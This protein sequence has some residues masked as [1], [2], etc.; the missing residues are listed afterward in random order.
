MGDLLKLLFGAIGVTLLYGS[1]RE[2]LDASREFTELTID[3]VFFGADVP[4]GDGHPVMVLPGLLAS[5]SY[6]IPLRGWLGRMGYAALASGIRRNT[7]RLAVLA[8]AVGTRL[9]TAV[10]E[11]RSPDARATLIGHSFGGV[12]ARAVARQHPE[13]VR[14]LI[15]LGSPL[16]FDA[17][18][19][20]PSIPLT[21]IYT[22]SDR[23][24]RY[25]RALAPEGARSL[26]VSG[27]HCGMAFN[28]QVYR[29]LGVLLQPTAP[30]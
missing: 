7:G 4:R 3:P 28:A 24:V 19:L 6:L 18:P 21:A 10:P 8:A 14:Q 5:D 13:L 27:S 1:T 29:H 11:P 30:G 16:R 15:T 22:R 12:I 17:A 26:E 23:I 2:M 9:A 20:A 25:P